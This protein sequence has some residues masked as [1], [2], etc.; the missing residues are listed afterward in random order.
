MTKRQA[1]IAAVEA[2]AGVAQKRKPSMDVGVSSDGDEEEDGS[3]SEDRGRRTTKVAKK[4]QRVD[5][6]DKAAAGKAKP[7]KKGGRSKAQ[8]ADEDHQMEDVVELFPADP[9]EALKAV[10]QKLQTQ[11]QRVEHAKA[12][13]KELYELKM[14]LAAPESHT[15]QNR[16]RD[17]DCHYR[18]LTAMATADAEAHATHTDTTVKRQLDRC[19]A[20]L[21][22]IQ[23]KIDKLHDEEVVEPC[24]EGLPETLWMSSD[25]KFGLGAFVGFVPCLTSLSAVSTH[26]HTLT[27]DS[28]MHPIIELNISPPNDIANELPVQGHFNHAPTPALIRL[29]ESLK[30]TITSID[31]NGYGGI[32]LGETEEQIVF[33]QLHKA[34]V[35]GAWGG[36]ARDRNFKLPALKHLSGDTFS[37]HGGYSRHHAVVPWIDSA[38]DGLTS[39]H[40]TYV[41]SLRD[42]A[43]A[44]RDTPTGEKLAAGDI[45]IETAPVVCLHVA[46]AKTLTSLSGFKFSGNDQDHNPYAHHPWYPYGLGGG[47]A[48]EDELS[49]LISAPQGA[50]LQKIEM[51]F[52]N[53]PTPKSIQR[54]H[55]F[56]AACLAPDA[57]ETYSPT[58]HL[59]LP[60]KGD[61]AP[62]ATCLP[63]VQLCC[64]KAD[65]VTLMSHAEDGTGTAALSPLVC[66]RARKLTIQCSYRDQQPPQPAYPHYLAHHAQAPPRVTQPIP[67]YITS[68]AHC[69]FPSV[70]SLGV[71]ERDAGMRVYAGGAGVCMGSLPSLEKVSFEVR[72]KPDPSAELC[73]VPAGLS[74]LSSQGNNLTVK[75]SIDAD[76]DRYLYGGPANTAPADELSLNWRVYSGEGDAGRQVMERRVSRLEI[77]L[78]VSLRHSR[79]Q[80][81]LSCAAAKDMCQSFADCV[82][83]AFDSCPSLSCVVLALPYLYGSRFSLV[84]N[85]KQ[86]VKK[87][88]HTNEAD[89]V[90]KTEEE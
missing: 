68:N 87:E 53:M 45:A 76:V 44:I 85:A 46:T 51:R 54:I 25:E 79:G 40:S 6:K 69:L 73:L 1:A 57:I 50:K 80:T 42:V 62:L 89:T 82:A 60:F 11:I 48:P 31:L 64:A 59:W 49:D 5:E 21:Q 65:S 4:K 39:I 37:R 33:P 56:R 35:Q 3:E 9:L 13:A 88:T 12:K 61:A 32:P 72:V 8:A 47:K 19:V 24:L 17:V 22:I 27:Q 83:E 86:K 71:Y 38:C 30:D 23:D 43:A 78:R 58:I 77:E 70:V 36:V 55:R 74:F 14:G 34:A 41:Q 28:N 52:P 7:K 67:S 10:A 84:D 81:G 15:E 18:V 16:I 29:L 20:K 66:E 26:F 63:T 75:S 90:M 2:A